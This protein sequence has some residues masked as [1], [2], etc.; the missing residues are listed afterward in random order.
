[1]AIS[2]I[3]SVLRSIVIWLIKILSFIDVP[4]ISIISPSYQF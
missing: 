3:Y 4:E 1:M 2:L